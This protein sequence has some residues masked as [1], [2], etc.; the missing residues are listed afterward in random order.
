MTPGMRSE[1]RRVA[2]DWSSDVCSS[3]LAVVAKAAPAVEKQRAL[4]FALL[5]G[6]VDV[7]EPPGGHDAGHGGVL[8]LLPIEPPEVD[9]LLFQRMV[10]KVHVVGGVLLV[11]DVEGNCFSRRRIDAHG[12][13]HRG[14][15]LL[16]RLNA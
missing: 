10:E 13:G 12:R 9:S 4:T 5:V 2:S 8:L 11:C 1:E 6:E 14:I 3:D 16:P 15:S 7:V